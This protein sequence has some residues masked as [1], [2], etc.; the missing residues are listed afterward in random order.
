M[1]RFTISPP[2]SRLL[3]LLST[4]S[5]MSLSSVRREYYTRLIIIVVVVV[6]VVVPLLLLS[7]EQNAF[8]RLQLTHVRVRRRAPGVGA[9]RRNNP[10]TL[11]KKSR[12]IMCMVNNAYNSIEKIFVRAKQVES[13]NTI[14][15]NC[16]NFKH[17]YRKHFNFLENF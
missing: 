1:T 17:V 13:K 2:G 14:F 3:I 12:N 16:I 4:L 6:I 15:L 7:D 11:R 9:V 5:T 8:Y 10:R